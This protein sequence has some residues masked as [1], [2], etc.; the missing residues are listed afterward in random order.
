MRLR[1]LVF[2]LLSVLVASAPVMPPVMAP[3][4]A[5]AQPSEVRTIRGSGHPI[6]RFVTLKADEVNM[7]AGPGLHFPIQ[8][9][10]RHAGYP[11]KVI[12][13]FDAWREV[14]DHYGD[15]GWMHAS[16][17]SFKRSAAVMQD[18]ALIYKAA[19]LSSPPLAQ[20]EAEAVLD[21][22]GCTAIWCRVGGERVRGW[23]PKNQLWGVLADEE[24]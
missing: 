6:P 13:E 23:I 22:L 4:I 5:H 17:L 7:R 9:V 18:N 1:V 11:M 15:R 19:S 12:G 3:V 24:F 21:V 16:V 2:C 20:A 8:F 10:Y 14:L